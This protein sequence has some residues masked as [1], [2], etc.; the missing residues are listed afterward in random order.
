VRYPVIVDG[1]LDEIILTNIYHIP[2]IEYNLLSIATLEYK[3]CSAKIK[4]RRLDIIDDLDDKK[5]LSGTCVGTSY[6]LDL[7]YSKTLYALKSNNAV[8]TL[9]K[10][11]GADTD[12]SSD[13]F[14][15]DIVYS[16][17]LSDETA[18][19]SPITTSVLEAEAEAETQLD[20]EDATQLNTKDIISEDEKPE[21]A[22]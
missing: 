11:T 8:A 17:N 9:S 1:K 4:N 15:E 14:S 2:A 18:I 21:P 6:L 7:K 5:V 12:D 20:T 13:Y 22:P 10:E 3:G 16:N 19:N